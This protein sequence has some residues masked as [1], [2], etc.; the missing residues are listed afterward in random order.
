M[1]LLK[2][3]YFIVDNRKLRIFVSTPMVSNYWWSP[4]TGKIFFF[5]FWLGVKETGNK[6][7]FG[8]KFL[9]IHLKDEKFH[10][11]T[12]RG[13]PVILPFPGFWEGGAEPS[14]TS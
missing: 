11:L 14:P 3:N 9:H 13:G 2:K 7:S 6:V 1:Y 8:E 5:F 4:I 12:E 10:T